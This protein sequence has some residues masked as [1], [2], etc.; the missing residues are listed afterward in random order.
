MIRIINA[1]VIGNEQAQTL[2]L[3]LE[4]AGI[5]RSSIRLIESSMEAEHRDDFVT[6]RSI[7]WGVV[8][9]VLGS[10]LGWLIM[11]WWSLPW[12]GAL[13]GAVVGIICAANAH[14]ITFENR[15][16]AIRK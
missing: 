10:A 1:R 5:A 13:W 2:I 15:F 16:A 12:I 7:G 4:K 6:S 8:G 9:A 14:S 3:D 11:S